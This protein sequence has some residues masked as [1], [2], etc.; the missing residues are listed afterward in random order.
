MTQYSL[1]SPFLQRIAAYFKNEEAVQAPK[2][3]E[4]LVPT[5]DQADFTR[6]LRFDVRDPSPT[7]G[8]GSVTQIWEVPEDELWKIFSYVQVNQGLRAVQV[9]VTVDEPGGSQYLAVVARRTCPGNVNAVTTIVGD[10]EITPPVVSLDDEVV[11]PACIIVP[12][13][14]RLK[15]TLTPLLGNFN[16]TTAYRGLWSWWVEPAPLSVE[17]RVV[18]SEVVP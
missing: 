9:T 17:R 3:G 7:G 1:N 5:V 15:V 12:P 14:W 11:V 13:A 10:V 4:L 2:L 16:A 6:V 18:T 8:A